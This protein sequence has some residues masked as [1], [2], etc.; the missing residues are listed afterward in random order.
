MLSWGEIVQRCHWVQRKP[1]V[2]YKQKCRP[3]S[4]KHDRRQLSRQLRVTNM[5][6]QGLKF[7][8]YRFVLAHG[9]A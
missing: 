3:A 2:V 7:S 9:G 5:R 6:K 8:A 1:E 4:L